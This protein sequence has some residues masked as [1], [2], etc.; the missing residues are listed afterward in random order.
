MAEAQTDDASSSEIEIVEPSDEQQSPA[1]TTRRPLRRS[2]V[3]VGCVFLAIAVCIN[4]PLQYVE[5]NSSGGV[6]QSTVDFNFVG[7]DLPMMAGAPFRYGIWYEATENLPST[8]AFSWMAVLLNVLTCGFVIAAFLYYLHRKSYR[9]IGAR[10]N[11]TI[12]DLL[13]L[14]FVVAGLF[15]WWQ[16]QDAQTKADKQYA[17]KLGGRVGGVRRS[18]WIPKLLKPILPNAVTK[19]LVAIRGIRLENPKDADLERMLEYRTIT[20]LRLGGGDYDLAKLQALKQQLHLTDLRIAGRTLDQ[21]TIEAL[22]AHPRLETL[23]LMRTNVTAQVL[24]EIEQFKSL[25]RLNLMHSDV[26]L[27]ELG[28]PPWADSIE[29][30]K[31]PHPISGSDSIAI[32]GWPSLVELSVN[33][34]D[35]TANPAPVGVQLRNL[36]KLRRLQLDQFQ[37]FDLTLNR[38]PELS[39]I[40]LLKENFQSRLPQGGSIPGQLWVRSIN[41]E[42]LQKLKELVIYVVDMDS[43]HV[44]ET[45]ALESLLIG[46]FRN[47]STGADYL[48]LDPEVAKTMID[49]VSQTTAKLLDLDSVPLGDVDL[50]PL[51]QNK[52]VTTLLLGDSGTSVKQWTTLKGMDRLVNL[53][54]SG[55]PGSMSDVKRLLDAFPSLQTLD[56]RE[57]GYV[58]ENQVF[59][60]NVG[61][62][63]LELRDRK[64]LRRLE[65]DRTQFGYQNVFITDM[66]RLQERFDFGW[67]AG[68]VQIRNAPALTGLSFMS[69]LPPK[70]T[71]Q[72]L[73]DLQYF[74][75]GGDSVNGQVVTALAA[76]KNLNKI[77]LAYAGAN[78]ESLK[79]LPVQSVANL[80][81]PG[82]NVTDSVLQAWNTLPLLTTAD[83]SHTKIT[84]AGLAVLSKSEFLSTLRLDGCNIAPGDLG[85]VLANKTKLRTLSLV[86]V[87]IDDETLKKLVSHGELRKIDLSGTKVSDAALDALSKLNLQ[88]LVIRDAEFDSQ[89]LLGLMRARPSLMLDMSGSEMDPGVWST[90]MNRRRIVD[91]EEYE[92]QMA[93]QAAMNS[94]NTRGTVY[95]NPMSGNEETVIDPSLFAPDG[96][97]GRRP[98]PRQ[99]QTTPAFQP[100]KT[101]RWLQ[102]LFTGGEEGATRFGTEEDAD[103]VIPE[104]TDE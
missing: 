6:T 41:V 66:P 64:Q 9:P 81:L 75:A 18:A 12:A 59:F 39:E 58:E 45:P 92:Q 77:T 17:N 78:E 82:C 56:C 86:D 89:K 13:L 101:V 7:T 67:V 48:P 33:E 55:N 61:E 1:K 73:R 23:N 98:P 46:V 14:T 91:A 63:D 47:T 20:T 57:L 36:P 93:M 29:V 5:T 74:A 71:L 104:L 76:C 84:G 70:V 32:D 11:V 28:R 65:M 2:T 50:S 103:E 37:C 94:A 95:F 16:Y 42:N 26:R 72:G 19:Q 44:Q 27:S 54:V 8:S 69:P 40:E 102:R 52:H 22:G 3:I 99:Q 85:P 34:L 21:P 97:Y 87:G 88:L 25:R 4:L 51:S 68:E 80:H 79:S 60:S 96:M 38:L 24:T 83:F 15:G 62:A 49:G 35:T 30:L 90:L 53:R 31:L 100:P 10:K 43:F